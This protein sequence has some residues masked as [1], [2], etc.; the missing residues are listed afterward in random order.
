MF[1]I[2]FY[3]NDK[4]AK[5]VTIENESRYDMSDIRTRMNQMKLNRN[6]TN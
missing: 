3:F 6:K 1:Y 4:I 5:H 2:D